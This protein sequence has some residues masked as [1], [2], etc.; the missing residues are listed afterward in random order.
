[1]SR[2]TYVMIAGKSYPMSFS[3]G[4]SKKIVEKFGSVE[5]M[6]A[7]L[8]RKGGDTEK[9]DIVIDI[10]AL[11]IA[12]GCAYKNYFEKDMPAPENA[13]LIEGKWEP[14]PRD[15]LEIAIQLPDM[16]ELTQKIQ[17]CIG[18]GGKKEVDAKATGKN[19]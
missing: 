14:L 6:Q 11:L 19:V 13:P 7:T 3:L 8:S 18:N 12:Q 2:I 9:L 16:E 10:L 17:E 4:A 5:K 1:M 15:I